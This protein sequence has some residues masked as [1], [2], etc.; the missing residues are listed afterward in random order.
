MKPVRWKE[1]KGKTRQRFFFGMIAGNMGQNMSKPKRR[2]LVDGLYT[3]VCC[4]RLKRLALGAHPN[5]G[6]FDM[7]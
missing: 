3:L 5:H 2:F 6:G 4:R 1:P 7:F